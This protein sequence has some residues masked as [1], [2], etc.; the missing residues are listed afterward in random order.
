MVTLTFVSKNYPGK[1]PHTVWGGKRI[2]D[3][4]GDDDDDD[5]DDDDTHMRAKK[6]RRMRAHES[7]HIRAHI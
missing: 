4:G 7:R 5:D 2:Q 6:S 1:R 3:Y